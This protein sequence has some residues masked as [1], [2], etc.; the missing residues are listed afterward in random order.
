MST[1][2]G[3]V[4]DW[5]DAM[6]SGADALSEL[7]S[8][9]PG[10]SAYGRAFC[11]VVA[12]TLGGQALQGANIGNAC[13]AFWDDDGIEPPTSG[14]PFTGGQCVGAPY[15]V[16]WEATTVFGSFTGTNAVVGPVSSRSEMDG[17]TF[18]CFLISLSG[19]AGEQEQQVFAQNLGNPPDTS[20]NS[21]TVS[22][23]TRTDGQPDDCGDPPGF[24]L[25][26]PDAP[27]VSFGDPQVVTGPDGNDYNI[28]PFDFTI[29]DNNE[30]NIPFEINGA[31]FNYG[32]G[33]ESGPATPGPTTEG[34][35]QAGGDEGG[36]RDVPEAPAGSRCIAIAFV[37][38][39]FTASQGNVTNS[40]PNRRL[41][42]VFGNAA[43]RVRTDQGGEYYL[44]NVDLNSERLLVP[45]PVE[46]LT[47]VGF[48]I[49]LETG[50]SYNA[51]PIYRTD[52]QE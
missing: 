37:V 10:V 34:A 35:P 21:F 47:I 38:S 46:G 39:G 9:L 28:T 44:G 11:R 52:I 43:V 25:P 50:L 3:E 1:K 13:S 12:G 42:A 40:E 20:A 45:I 29:G 22:S 4:T 18:R 14:V 15:N 23:T 27:G 19:E 6:Q 30:V 32:P 8:N 26:S 16:A 49:N 36:E 17:S 51:T 33:A 31:P 24:F 48:K 2:L 7:A 5:F 41:Y